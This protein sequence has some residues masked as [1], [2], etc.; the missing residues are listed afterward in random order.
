MSKHAQREVKRREKRADKS[1]A[2]ML[3]G[4]IGLAELEKLAYPELFEEP[5]AE[6]RIFVDGR[7]YIQNEAGEW[8]ETER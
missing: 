1:R 2:I 3:K 5:G 8:K 4:L 7:E 6:Q